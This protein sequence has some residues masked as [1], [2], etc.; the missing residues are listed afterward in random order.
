MD[1]LY[2]IDDTVIHCRDVEGFLDI[3]DRVLSQMEKFNVRLKP[4][5]CFFVM[6][7]IEFL[8]HDFDKN[9]E[10]MSDS[11]VQGINDLPEL[12]SVKGVRSFIG[13]ANYFRDF[14]KGLA[15]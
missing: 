11:R 8:G 15:I 9:G 14:V 7:S 13:M 5:K 3:L 1:P 4:S 12:T 10:K 2:T 6:T